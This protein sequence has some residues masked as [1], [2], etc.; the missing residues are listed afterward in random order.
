MKRKK[1]LDRANRTGVRLFSTCV[2]AIISFVYLFPFLW[3]FFASFRTQ[4]D[5]FAVQQDLFT[6]LSLQSYQDM[7]GRMGITKYLVNSIIISVGGALLAVLLG[8]LAAY[9][10]VRYRF[11][12]KKAIACSYLILRM[13][14]GIS[15]MLP[16][17]LLVTKMGM[18]DRHL[19]VI[20]CYACGSIP[21]AVWMLQSFFSDIP[22][23]IDEAA[24][25][26]GCGRLKVLLKIMLPLSAP[27]LVA[28][29]VFIL[30]AMWNEYLY[31]MILTTG[32]AV[33]LPLSIASMNTAWGREWNRIAAIST[34]IVMP[35]LIFTISVQKYLIRGMTM[36]A[37]KG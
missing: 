37:V 33:T 12:G 21:I 34:V 36:G 32:N 19:T 15:L 30:V 13:L 28:A 26:D 25:I 31:A 1:T 27:G 16:I 11:R 23:E 35:M 20:V 24:R 5:I 29:M 3:F 7:F 2:T 4:K 6:P 8:G 22:S 10:L 17:Y 18:L 14:P 9:G